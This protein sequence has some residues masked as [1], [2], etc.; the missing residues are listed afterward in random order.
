[1]QEHNTSAT[2]RKHLDD[3]GIKYEFPVAKTGIVAKLGNGSPVV[4]LRA[5]IDALPIMEDSGVEFPSKNPGVMH[6]CGHDGHIAMLLGAARLLKR[7]ESKLQGTVVLLFQPAEEG[8]AGGDLM[9]KEGAL[10]GVDS[11]FGMHLWPNLP[12]GVVGTRAGTIMAGS[13]EFT[14]RFEGAGGHG[15]MPHLTKDP[16]VA[17]AQAITAVQTLVSRNTSPFDSAVISVTKIWAGGKAFNGEF[18]HS[19]IGF[20][21]IAWFIKFLNLLIRS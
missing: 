9:I 5:D 21:P 20:F 1:M 3:L 12:T 18:S 7:M 16:V 4:A 15:A 14:V 2:I 10:E 8:G 6:A 19:L 17:A 13:I 11:A